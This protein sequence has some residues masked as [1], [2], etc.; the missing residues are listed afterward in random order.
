MCTPV[1]QQQQQRRTTALLTNQKM[2]CTTETPETSIVA[3]NASKLE[4]DS[5]ALASCSL[6]E[7]V[8]AGMAKISMQKPNI[9]VKPE[10]AAEKTDDGAKT[11]KTVNN[12]KKLGCVTAALSAKLPI[13]EVAVVEGR[14]NSAL[15]LPPESRTCPRK[16]QI[17][18]GLGAHKGSETVIPKKTSF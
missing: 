1:Q 3:E 2:P 17:S 4:S 5:S 18:E 8:V 10:V 11:T 15:A 16:R 7:S 13:R 14:Q 12:I 6:N 9:F